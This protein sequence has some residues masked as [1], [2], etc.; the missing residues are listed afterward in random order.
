[1]ARACCKPVWPQSS[2]W[3]LA[4]VMS[5]ILAAWKAV[6]ALAGAW[7]TYCLGCGLGQPAIVRANSKFVIDRSTSV[8][9]LATFPSSAVAGSA[10]S[11]VPS[12]P[13]K[14][15]SPPK[16]NVTGC[17]FPRQVGESGAFPPPRAVLEDARLVESERQLWHTALG[18]TRRGRNSDSSN[19]R[20]TGTD[21][22]ATG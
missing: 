22:A 12:A 4:S 1:M 2:P 6:I 7:K 19:R 15:T 3:L 14:C 20:V 10:A 13:S 18:V 17:P 11:R 5:V 8:N 16:P 9:R 21:R